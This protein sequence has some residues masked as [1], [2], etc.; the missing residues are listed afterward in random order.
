MTNISLVFRVELTR[1][2][3]VLHG[4]WITLNRKIDSGFTLSGL[5]ILLG[6]HFINSVYY[7]AV[8]TTSVP[9]AR[10]L[11]NCLS[12]CNEGSRCHPPST[13]FFFILLQSLER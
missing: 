1:L 3:T 12:L 7:I 8:I 5:L 4:I 2:N 13:G 11:P 6:G 10:Q 9:T